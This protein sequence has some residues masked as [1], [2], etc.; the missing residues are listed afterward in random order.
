MHNACGGYSGRLERGY[1]N[2][3]RAGGSRNANA[4]EPYSTKTCVDG[5]ENVHFPGI[6]DHHRLTSFASQPLQG[7]VENLRRWLREPDLFG[8]H[9]HI[10]ERREAAAFDFVALFLREIVRHNSD[11]DVPLQFLE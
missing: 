6:S 1:F 9:Q 5:S 11:R 10:D 2:N 3:V 8:G 7:L 4:I